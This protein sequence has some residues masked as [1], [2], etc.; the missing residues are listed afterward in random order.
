M[1]STT[2]SR[3]AVTDPVAIALGAQP[4][5]AETSVNYSIGGVLRVG[6]LNVTVDAYR[7]D[8]TDR[9]VL[10]ENLTQANV[11][12]YLQSQGFIG[13]GGGRFFLNGVDTETTG[14]DIVANYTGGF[15]IHT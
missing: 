13:S 2:C 15:R 4:L 5:D 12:A 1:T 8:V 6:G 11:R 7:I 3:F 14:V 9:V 10:S